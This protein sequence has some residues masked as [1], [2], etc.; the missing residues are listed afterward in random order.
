MTVEKYIFWSNIQ[1]IADNLDDIFEH[2]D[3]KWLEN[4][5]FK[6]NLNDN[7]Q[8]IDNLLENRSKLKWQM[9]MIHLKN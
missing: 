6:E 3:D 1:Y 5:C 8:I 7:I 2:R 4:L 9:K